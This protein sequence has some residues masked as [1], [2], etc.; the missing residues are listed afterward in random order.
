MQSLE[1]SD[2]E[3]SEF[4]QP[5]VLFQRLLELN[6]LFYAKQ[7]TVKHII[8]GT[9]HIL[10]TIKILLRT[11]IDKKL[12]S[13]LQYIQKQTEIFFK[14]ILTAQGF[15]DNLSKTNLKACLKELK[16]NNL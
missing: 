5:E 1:E 16:Q 11:N 9:Q 2:N 10:N 8:N 3:I 14:D 15:K 13:H 7:Q 4:Q 12:Q 6:Q